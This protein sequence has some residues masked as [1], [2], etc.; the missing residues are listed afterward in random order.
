MDYD[1]R[2]RYGAR[3]ASLERLANKLRENLFNHSD[4]HHA[5][6]HRDG[7]D[8]YSDDNVMTTTPHAPSAAHDNVY[9]YDDEAMDWE[10]VYDTMFHKY[11]TLR[12]YIYC[13]IL[14]LLILVGAIGNAVLTS[15]A[16]R[17]NRR[18]T[19]A[20][21]AFIINL[22]A[23]NSLFLLVCI[24]LLMYENMLMNSWTMGETMCQLQRYLQFCC[25]YALIYALL[26][27]LLH[28]YLQLRLPRLL[29]P[30]NTSHVGGA[31]SV[32]LWVAIMVG[33][34]PNLLGHGLYDQIEGV[35]FCYHEALHNWRKVQQ[36]IIVQFLF[37]YALP[38]LLMVAISFVLLYHLLYRANASHYASM[39]NSSG[40]GME[41]RGVT[42]CVTLT[43]MF[44]VCWSP[45]RVFSLVLAYSS[46]TYGTHLIVL[47]DVF[48]LL[49]CLNIAT[50]AWFVLLILREQL[51]LAPAAAASH[52][53][54][55]TVDAAAAAANGAAATAPEVNQN[56][57]HMFDNE[58]QPSSGGGNVE[59][60][61]MHM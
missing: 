19:S 24:P 57:Y 45:D 1:V 20:F 50:N 14:A 25:F 39:P 15:A 18:A 36:F 13:T 22:T 55:V 21:Y 44:T 60:L 56:G 3:N 8:A 34:I 41:R 37:S 42:L 32:L 6:L 38:L 7:G 16:L 33:N 27:L 23:T 40:R 51:Q 11:L 43:V 30:V 9:Y 2:H 28:T 49:A 54:H 53:S 58:S 31:I 52:R 26:L 59:Q 47:G 46:E 12:P 35:A 5:Y 29:A 10:T 48:V 4:S 61:E 17:C